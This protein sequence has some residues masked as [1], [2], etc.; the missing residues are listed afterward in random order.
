MKVFVA[1]RRE[2]DIEEAFTRRQTPTIQIKAKNVRQDID[3]FVSGRAE[4]LVRAGKLRI[5]DQSLI[6]EIVQT[7]SSRAEGML[8]LNI[9]GYS[10]RNV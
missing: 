2:H 7:L 8:V 5:T 9:T 3:V 4:E 10:L 1:S 6:S